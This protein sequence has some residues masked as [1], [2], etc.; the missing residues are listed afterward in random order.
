[1]TLIS[2]NLQDGQGSPHQ[3]LID[4]ESEELKQRQ[5]A[6]MLKS[7]EGRVDSI[8]ILSKSGDDIETSNDTDHEDPYLPSMPPKYAAWP[9]PIQNP[10]WPLAEDCSLESKVT[11]PDLK[12]FP[13]VF[14][15]P[16]NKGF[17]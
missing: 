10:D 2:C 17:K 1:M 6:D 8:G 12:D 11:L 3:Q 16:E 9:E 13:T 14:L 15:S 7:F 5:L 4:D